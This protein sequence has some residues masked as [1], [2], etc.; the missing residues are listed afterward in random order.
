MRGRQKLEGERNASAG[1]RRMILEPEQLL[2]PQRNRRPA[3]GLVVDRRLGSGRGAEV[4]RR[5]IVEAAREIPRETRGERLGEVVGAD[6]VEPGLAWEER[7]Q[8]AGV[9][10]ERLV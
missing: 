8:P 10:C 7:R 6:L 4:G 9:G 5:L 2:H 3:F 1:Q